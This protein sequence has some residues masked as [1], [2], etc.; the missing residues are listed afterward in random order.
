VPSLTSKQSSKRR[1]GQ[2]TGEPLTYSHAGA[3][4]AALRQSVCVRN[5]TVCNWLSCG[6]QVW[7]SKLFIITASCQ[8]ADSRLWLLLQV[9]HQRH[10]HGTLVSVA[11]NTIVTKP[12]CLNA[13]NCYVTR[14]RVATQP[15]AGTSTRRVQLHHK[16]TAAYF[17]SRQ[18]R[19]STLNHQQPATMMSSTVQSF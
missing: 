8:A 19:P 7:L 1:E 10:Q 18:S 16:C 5:A 9:R 12:A 17:I 6:R 3:A 13:Y 2:C 4:T 15:A 11:C 14:P